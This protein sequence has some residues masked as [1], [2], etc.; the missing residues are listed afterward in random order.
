MSHEKI[1]VVEDDPSV[2]KVLAFTLSKEGYSVETAEDGLDGLEKATAAPPDLVL[3][4]LMM[5]RMDGAQLCKQLKG[6][7]LTSQIP[8][9]MLTARGEMDAKLAGLTIGANDYLT[10]PYATDELLVRVRNI[11]NFSR[12]QRQA[13]PLTGL[14]GNISIDA[15]TAR[16][17][18]CGEPFALLYVDIDNFKAYNDYYSFEKGDEAIKLT[19][20]IILTAVAKFGGK[21]DFVGHVGG[22]DFV[23]MST[24]EHGRAIADAIVEAFDRQIAA[25][26]TDEDR[27]RGYIEVTNRQNVVTRYPMMTI[28]VAGV[29]NVDRKITHV[30]QISGLAAEMK[31]FGKQTQKSIA[32]WERRND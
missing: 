6:H 29:S 9:I 5:P 11:L 24:P 31:C 32:V 7:F 10:K 25:L 14:P 15:E 1:L 12:I 27:T 28:T 23:I 19:S 20:S 26:Y 22:D 18:E 13:N 4:D 16:R 8:V 2:R 17:I 30:G 3:L 21:E